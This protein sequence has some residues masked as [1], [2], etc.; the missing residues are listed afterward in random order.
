VNLQFLYKKKKDINVCFLFFSVRDD[1]LKSRSANQEVFCRTATVRLE[2]KRRTDNP[3]GSG[4]FFVRSF[5][6]RLQFK[7]LVFCWSVTRHGGIW[8]PSGAP[9]HVAQVSSSSSSCCC[10]AANLRPSCSFIL[11]PRCARIDHRSRRSAVYLHL[12]EPSTP[13]ESIHIHENPLFLRLHSSLWREGVH[14]THAICNC[15]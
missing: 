4:M 11:F 13:L 8:I 15:R 1:F 14:E 12:L 3:P 10:L 2:V 6:W 9:E 7:A 5:R